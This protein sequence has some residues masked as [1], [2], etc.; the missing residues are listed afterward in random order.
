[1]NEE[2]K[3]K[4]SYDDLKDPKVDEIIARETRSKADIEANA[5]ASKAEKR[6]FFNRR[7]LQFAVVVLMGAFIFWGIVKVFDKIVSPKD[8]N[9]EIGNLQYVLSKE[10]QKYLEILATS[11]YEKT[12]SV[13]IIQEPHYNLGQ[14][15]NLYKG[16]EVFFKDN[17]ALISKTIFLS[18]GLPAK[19]ALSVAPLVEVEPHP[20]YET[21]KDVLSSFLITGYIAYEWKYQKNI[22]IVGIEDKR[23]YDLSANLWVK[24][25]D[26]PEDLNT[27]TFWEFSVVARNKSMAQTLIDKVKNYENPILFVGGL[28][29]DKQSS[30]DFQKV[31]NEI[32][33]ESL[34][35][36]DAVY[37]NAYENFGIYDYLKAEKIGYTFVDAL[38]DPSESA[39]KVEENV[40]IYTELFKAQQAGDYESYIEWL[41][42]ETTLTNGVTVASSTHAAA[43][44][45]KA[46][47]EAKKGTGNT[48]SNPPKTGLSCGGGTKG[49]GNNGNKTPK[50]TD[51]KD[52]NPEQWKAGPPNSEPAKGKHK[53]GTS[54]ETEYTNKETGEK[55]WR[56][57]IKDK[58]GNV[59]HD[60][61]RPFPKHRNLNMEITY[62]EG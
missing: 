48:S 57:T 37:L 6:R 17:P 21:I 11:D 10:A 56:H 9:I 52:F 12:R 42:S 13:I 61:F 22:P 15:Y 43:K 23:V 59:V 30:E 58:N 44:F 55:Q 49:T 39:D 27:P 62:E 18:E 1:M 19:Q 41:I 46:S 24:T 33:G 4:V 40:L 36:D 14:Q 32:F 20:S 8:R 31:K 45:A 7:W 50:T 16:L 35:V 25:R 54:T 47:N 3:I 29:L 51:G 53:G 5:R 38:S 26:N 60:H 2:N 28:H 34:S